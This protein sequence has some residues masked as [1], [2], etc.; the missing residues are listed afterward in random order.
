MTQGPGSATEEEPL[1][2]L[3][4]L[5][6]QTAALENELATSDATA[7]DKPEQEALSTDKSAEKH[8]C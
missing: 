3:S 1:K 7:S 2:P 6:V 4:Q 8:P 5:T